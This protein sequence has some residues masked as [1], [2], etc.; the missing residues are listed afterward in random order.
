MLVGGFRLFVGD[1]QL[2]AAAG[3]SRRAARLFIPCA[4]QFPT[5]VA[6]EFNGQ[7]SE[8]PDQSGRIVLFHLSAVRCPVR[9]Q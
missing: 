3:T 2:L 6:V 9:R 5:D 1:G 8:S 4:K 7:C